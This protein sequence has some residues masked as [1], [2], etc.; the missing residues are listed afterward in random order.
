MKWMTKS[1]E[2]AVST[3]E[4]RNMKVLMARKGGR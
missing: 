1:N 4:W 2:L 3:L